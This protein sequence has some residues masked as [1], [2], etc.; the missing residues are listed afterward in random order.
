MVQSVLLAPSM[1][2]FHRNR[3]HRLARWA[4]QKQGWATVSR[5]ARGVFVPPRACWTTMAVQ[6]AAGSVAVRCPA[7]PGLGAGEACTCAGC[8]ERATAAGGCWC[9]LWRWRQPQ[10]R[11]Q[12][13]GTSYYC[14]AATAM[15]SAPNS[16]KLCCAVPWGC[17]GNWWYMWTAQGTLAPYW[18]R[19]HAVVRA[20]A[21]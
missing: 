3:R 19:A 14:K 4:A 11:G 13:G 1:A 7:R 10:D 8:A 9:G 18:G 17:P 2:P 15:R 20:G 6:K 12:R 5:P 21:A 16:P